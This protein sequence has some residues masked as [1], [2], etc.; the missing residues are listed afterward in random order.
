MEQAHGGIILTA[1]HNPKQW[2]ALKLLNEKGEFISAKDGGE[3]LKMAK[4]TRQS[5]PEVTEL[6]NVEVK[7]G[8]IEKHIA[9]IVS[10]P[11]VDPEAIAKRNFKIAVDAVNSSGG[12][13]VPQLLKALG[14]KQI[15]EINCVP[16]GN[17]A[18]NPE[19]LPENL[20]DLSRTVTK[21]KADLG[22]SVDPDVD[23][24]AFVSEDGSMFGEEYTLVTV[25][26]YI[27]KN[28]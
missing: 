8:Y 18:H 13:A 11:L 24:L 17:F 9:Q 5:F 3:L 27:L 1:S 28:Q 2:N 4:K 6:G 23:R 25:A 12:L 16:D 14:V 19:P 10:L 7:S 22:I 15:T 21:S 20:A 26:D